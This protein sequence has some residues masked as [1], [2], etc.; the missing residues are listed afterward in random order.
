VAFQALISTSI[1]RMLF[2]AGPFWVVLLGTGFQ[3]WQEWVTGTD[4]RNL[5]EKEAPSVETNTPHRR[6]AA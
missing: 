2:V 4:A 1:V 3:Q 5:S 6:H